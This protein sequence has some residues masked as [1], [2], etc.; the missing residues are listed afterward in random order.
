MHKLLPLLGTCLM[1]AACTGT[2]T[3]AGSPTPGV[4]P[5]PPATPA[6]SPGYAVATDPSKLILR[7]AAGGGFI[8]P[9]YLL[10][11]VPEFALYGDGRI[12]VPGPVD[13]IYPSPLLPNLL[14]ARVTPAE[15]QKIVT[16]ADS[17][18]LLGPD[19]TFDVV[20]IADASTTVFTT[21]VNGKAHR[22]GAYALGE[23]GGVG[24]HGPVGGPTADPAIAAARAKLSAFRAQMTDL[25]TFLGRP[26]SETEVYVAA[27]M[28][29]FLTDVSP[30]D[31]AQPT[32]PAQPAAPD[33]GQPAL[34]VVVWPLSADPATAGQPTTVPGTVCVLLTGGD[35]SSF[36]AVASTANAA[37]MW[38]YGKAR[39]A[40]TVHP[41]YPNES[42][43]A[44]SSL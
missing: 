20:G 34:Q 33:P 40:V 1:V 43:C 37:T 36:V 18:G 17:A 41:L 30:A 12:I 9:T 6:V 2:G 8:A 25:A 7:I 44:G 16:A 21:V 14:V 13:A 31:P 27:G 35:L 5:N 19:A 29:A 38:T 28:R 22:I 11:A 4:S 23:A 15:I 3:G 24:G 39:Y 42:S 10:A 32:H 26:V